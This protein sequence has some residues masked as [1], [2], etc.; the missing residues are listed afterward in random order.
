MSE[1]LSKQTYFD[2]AIGFTFSYYDIP[3]VD[4]LVMKLENQIEQLK[5]EMRTDNSTVIEKMATEIA[6]LK[7]KRNTTEKLLNKAL[8]CISD[9]KKHIISLARKNNHS[10]YKRCLAMARWCELGISYWDDDEQ[11]GGWEYK[12]LRHCIRWKKRWLE[13]AEK[14]KE[15]K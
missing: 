11:E 8:N 3:E 14:F 7:E 6:E 4:R 5:A 1:Q 15:V 10:N 13:L 9:D 2:Q 12:K